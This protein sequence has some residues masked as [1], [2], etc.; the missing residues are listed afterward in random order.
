MGLFNRSRMKK[1]EDL[2]VRIGE[3]LLQ[4]SLLDPSQQGQGQ[5][6]L[7][8]GLARLVCEA[9]P[10]WSVEDGF[11]ERRDR[12]GRINA[13]AHLA[14]LHTA[15]DLLGVVIDADLREHGRLSQRDHDEVL[16]RALRRL[17]TSLEH[18]SLSEVSEA[19]AHETE[20]AA[21]WEELSSSGDD[22]EEIA[23]ARAQLEEL[24]E[25]LLA[26]AYGALAFA[27]FL[28]ESQVRPL[29]AL[30]FFTSRHCA[31]SMHRGELFYRGAAIGS[32]TNDD[33]TNA[34]YADMV[35]A[36]L[37]QDYPFLQDTT[38][39]ELTLAA[40][41]AWD[42]ELASLFL[43]AGGQDPALAEALAARRD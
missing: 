19:L 38:V 13:T 33:P 43:R 3:N 6:E 16:M 36:V 25:G 41:R 24:A 27:D 20:T 35:W 8:R 7:V 26:A 15:L 29:T 4:Q 22:P 40:M 42:R 14:D 39:R 2:A 17:S 9:N 28:D 34:I 18:R 11:L 32:Y 21:L 23:G 5:H 10:A 12:T 31:W 1:A 37:E 30:R